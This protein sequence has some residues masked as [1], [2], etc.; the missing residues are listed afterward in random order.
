[1]NLPRDG[2]APGADEL[3]RALSG[4]H[5]ST[6]SSLLAFRSSWVARDTGTAH[7]L[8]LRLRRDVLS[9]LVWEESALLS[10]FRERLPQAGQLRAIT[11]ELMTHRALRQLLMDV[12]R[13]FPERRSVDIALDVRISV[14]LENLQQQVD[15]HGSRSQDQLCLALADVLPRS[16][17]QEMAC[18]IRTRDLRGPR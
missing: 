8:F 14:L 16:V 13:L 10:P 15:V 12:A 18:E 7:K 6:R 3:R 17:R 2:I 5:A 9:H 1:M 11:E 4:N